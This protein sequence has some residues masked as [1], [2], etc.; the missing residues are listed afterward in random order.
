M[1]LD[2]ASHTIRFHG[3]DVPIE[4]PAGVATSSPWCDVTRSMPSCYKNAYLDYLA[5]PS[6]PSDDTPFSTIPFVPDD[7]WP[8]SPPRADI[9]CNSSIIC[10]PLVSPLAAPAELWKNAPPIWISLGEEGLTD[11]GLIVARRLH[12]AGVPLVAEMFEGMPHCHGLL[13]LGTPASRR[14]FEG[15]SGFCRDAVAGRVKSAG[16][17]TWLSFKLQSSKDI[18]I[19]EACAT[20][21][22][23]AQTLM[24]RNAA[25]RLKT[26]VEMLKEWHA[27]AKL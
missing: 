19:E 24:Q 6:Q 16:T 20:S 9:F 14:F 4:L 26:E 21:D 17:L 11:E 1:T 3:K 5:P 22:E 12:Q 10:H 8:V 7:V 15:F 13:M 18:P 25:W 27:K 2:R 23:Q